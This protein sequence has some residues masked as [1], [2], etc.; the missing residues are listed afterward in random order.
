LYH[1]IK[2]YENNRKIKALRFLNKKYKELKEL[3]E[4]I[5]GD[6]MYRIDTSKPS[7]DLTAFKNK[8]ESIRTKLQQFD[9]GIGIKSWLLWEEAWLGFS[10]EVIEDVLGHTILYVRWMQEELLKMNK[11]EI[12]KLNDR[13]NESIK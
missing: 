4:R 8:L 13:D 5:N 7:E 6:Y 11:M 1:K 10:K 12:N 2:G 3:N 9:Y